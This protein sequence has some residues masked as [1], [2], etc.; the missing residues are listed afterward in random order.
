[1]RG[2]QRR[3]LHRLLP[4]LLS[5][6]LLVGLIGAPIASGDEL[7]EAQARQRQLRDSI[8]QQKSELAKLRTAQGQLSDALSA[9]ARELDNVHA[10]QA[11]ARRKIERAT[12]ALEKVQ[13]RYERL[14]GKLEHLDWTLGVLERELLAAETDLEARRSV[15]AARL[16]EAYRT[17]QTSLLEQVM[18]AQS[19]SDVLANVGTHLAFGNQDAQLAEGIER[20]QI[21]LEGLR[22]TTA[23]ARYQTDQVRLQV[24]REAVALRR[25]REELRAAKRQLDRLERQT[26]QVQARQ[27]Q[28]FEQVTEERQQ[29]A[30]TLQRQLRAEDQL[31]A[32]ILRLVEE[33]RRRQA[34]RLAALEAQRQ[35]EAAAQRQREAEA[36]AR[37]QAE[38]RARQEREQ[39]QNQQPGATPRPQPE[40]ESEPAPEAPPAPEPSGGFRWP[41]NGRVSQEFGCTGFGW[42]PP[43]GSCAHFHRGID[44]VAPAGTAIRAAGPGTVVF[45]GYNPYDRPSDPAWIVILSHPNGLT[46]WYAHMQPRIPAGISTG[47]SVSAGQVVGYEG[48]TGNST[49]PHLHW[50]VLN[51]STFVNPRLYL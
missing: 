31:K 32:D 36:E 19:F 49:G 39:E 28:T 21:A 6:P 42:E 17:G 43:L 34:E 38:E 44:I 1:M 2:R 51:G 4:V 45:V 46:T 37:R 30:R 35:R 24:R 23:S 7:T 48:N 13:A 33:Q 29:S 5:V 16:E 27:E 22:R 25:H 50:A 47:A 12:A 9:T 41:M 8:A 18:A 15:L 3:R 14:L 20:D 26:Q 40:P 11:A 10:D